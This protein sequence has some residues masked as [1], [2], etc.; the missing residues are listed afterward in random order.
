MIVDVGQA[1]TDLSKLIAR[2]EA[3]EDV[4]IAR[5]GVPVVRLV[6]VEPSSAPGARFLAMRGALSGR[7][8]IPDDFEFDDAE[9]DEMFD[10]PA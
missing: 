1:K 9:L 3:G 8:T 2:A 5:S 6:P 4:E 10:G 7:I